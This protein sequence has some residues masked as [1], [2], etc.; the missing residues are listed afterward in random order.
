VQRVEPVL[1]VAQRREEPA[2]PAGA[3]AGVEVRGHAHRRPQDARQPDPLRGGE[4]T[5]GEQGAHQDREP[6]PD[7]QQPGTGGQ[8]G[9]DDDEAG[10]RQGQADHDVA[11]VDAQLPPPA[12]GRR[13]R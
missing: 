13:R 6:D 11:G 4:P 8:P 7:D 1:R 9:G 12:A 10:D 5:G 3:D 2:D